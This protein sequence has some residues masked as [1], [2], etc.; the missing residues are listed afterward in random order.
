M[1]KIDFHIHTIQSNLDSDFTFC[2]GKLKEYIDAAHLDCVAITNHNLFEK[3]QFKKIIAEITIPAF[4]GI[5][6]DLEGAQILVIDD[7]TNLDDFDAKCTQISSL[8]SEKGDS[9]TVERLKNIFEDLSKYI[10]IP[11]YDKKPAIKEDTLNRLSPFVTAGEVSSPKKF[12]YCLKNNERLV[13]VYFS[14]CRISQDLTSIPIR[15]TYLDCDELSFAAVKTCLR[16]KNKVAL[17]ERD[18]NALFQVF[19]DG[20]KLS[21]GL[22]VVVG[23]RSSGKSHTLKR[24]SERIENVRYIEQFALV[25]R[26]EEEDKTKF[27]QHLSQKQ[28]LFSKEY[29]KELQSVVDDVLD[30]DLEEDERSVSRYIDTLLKYAKETEKH[31]VFSK[32]KLFSEET[33]PAIDQKGLIELI[34]STKNLLRNEE[35]RD[36]IDKHILLDSL[37]A[38]YVELM[39][40]FETKEQE[41]L[42]KNWINELVQHIKSKLQIKTAAPT[43]AELDPYKLVMN[44]KKVEKFKSLVSLARKPR[45]VLRKQQRGFE[46]VADV[47]PFKGAGE[48]KSLSK[49]QVAFSGAFPEYDDPYTYLQKLK[50]IDSRIPQADYYKYFVK[51]DYKILNKDGFEA[52]GGERSEFFLLQE[53]EDA[54]AFDMLLID[55]PESSFD[56]LFLK[57]EVNEIIKE[58]SKNMPVVLVTHNNTVG[59]SIRPDYLL[60]T[61]KE[62]EAGAV[63]WRIYSGFPT[64][65]KLQSV[66]GK[67]LN[68]WDVTMGCLEAGPD[69]YDERKQGYEDLKN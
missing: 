57:N 59:A 51:I 67:S 31:D 28:S 49:S 5:E 33:F 11:H 9:I 14:D 63:Q 48:L 41:R 53:I 21:T 22:N 26:N 35:F 16:D 7:R 65:K 19:E 18:G 3:E 52:S 39:K 44:S 6:I 29:L 34:D 58:I 62:I 27:N 12:M 10:L 8:C 46:I 20:Q 1:K 54:Q 40:L 61:K 36:I 56:N 50:K 68:I 23:E 66:D 45:E 60:C 13:P 2:F 30:T 4:P 15:Q 37:K 38:L 24:I 43:I 64:N 55:E 42:K 47:G 32:A 25:S 69:A 17:S